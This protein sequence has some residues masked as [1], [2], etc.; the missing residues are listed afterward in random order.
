M[1][2]ITHDFIPEFDKNTKIMILGTMPSPKSRQQGFYYGHPQNKMWKVLCHLLNEPLT[3][4]IDEKKALLHDNGIGMWDV[5]KSCVIEGAED[6]SIQEPEPNDFSEI[7]QTTNLRAVF[8]TGK[9]AFVLYEK[10]CEIQ[11]GIKAIYLPSTS[12]ANCGHY[13][14]K[15]LVDFYRQIL[16][17]M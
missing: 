5:L 17:F 12:P 10:F 14:F 15:R 3:V 13:D 2:K 1:E 9:K 6:S 7:I 8:T 11:T 4:T 16:D